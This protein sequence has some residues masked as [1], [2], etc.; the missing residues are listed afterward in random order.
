VIAEYFDNRLRYKDELEKQGL[1][2][3]GTVP[4]YR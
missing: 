1:K 2:V 4:K 3:L